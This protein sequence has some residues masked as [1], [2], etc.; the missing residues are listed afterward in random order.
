MKRDY[1]AVA[2]RSVGTI[3][4]VA[5]HMQYYVAP[6]QDLDLEHEA[7]LSIREVV[8]GTSSAS[9]ESVLAVDPS[10]ARLLS[11]AS[12]TSGGSRLLEYAR[13]FDEAHQS[14]LEATLKVSL[15]ALQRA[16]N[17]NSAYLN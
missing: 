8:A 7:A 11:N 9:F 10:L 2:E 1:Q 16:M 17:A 4:E 12:T 13:G 15:T 5:R 14:R 6:W 3:L